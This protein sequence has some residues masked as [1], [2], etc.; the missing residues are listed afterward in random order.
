MITP[1]VTAAKPASEWDA[2]VE[3]SGCEVYCERGRCIVGRSCPTSR[4][5]VHVRL[6]RI[7]VSSKTLPVALGVDQRVRVRVVVRDGSDAEQS[8][9]Q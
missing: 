3:R 4:E 2:P 9:V 8:P 1:T 5:S 6:N 7:A